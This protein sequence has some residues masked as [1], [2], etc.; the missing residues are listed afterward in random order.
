M[1]MVGMRAMP[2]GLSA[3]SSRSDDLVVVVVNHYTDSWRNRAFEVLPAGI[4][5]IPDIPSFLTMAAIPGSRG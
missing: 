1:E 5:I 2:A 3:S 4:A